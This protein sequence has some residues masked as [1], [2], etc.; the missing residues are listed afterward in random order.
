MLGGAIEEEFEEAAPQRK[1]LFYTEG[2]TLLKKARLQLI[3]P[4]FVIAVSRLAGAQSK[5]DSQDEDKADEQADAIA[6]MRKVHISSP[7]SPKQLTHSF[8]H[9]LFSS[10][11]VMNLVLQGCQLQLHSAGLS[12]STDLLFVLCPGHQ[13]KQQST[14]TDL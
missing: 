11:Y 8:T 4:V 7:F 5:H 12:R 3:I 14:N 13:S 10:F 6:L 9:S 1:E 2:T